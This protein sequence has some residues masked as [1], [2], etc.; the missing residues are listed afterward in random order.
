MKLKV[1]C[2]QDIDLNTFGI[3]KNLQ[4]KHN[5]DLFSII[6]VVNG[7][8]KFFQK[9]SL[10]KYLKKWFYYDHIFLNK[11]PD[12]EY[13]RS[14]E[15]NYKIDIWKIAYNDRIFFQYTD[16]Y[17]FHPDEILSIIEQGCK[18]FESILDEINPDFVVLPTTNSGR[19]HLFYEMCKAKNIPV[20]MLVAT[21]FGNRCMFSKEAEVIDY[22]DKL[23]TTN[24][25]RTLEELQN[26]LQGHDSYKSNKLFQNNQQTSKLQFFKAAITYFLFSK[27]SNL[28]TRY[29]HFGRTKSRVFFYYIKDMIKKNYRANFMN[30]NLSTKIDDGPFIFFPMITDPERSLLIAAPFHTNQF[31]LIVHIVKS[32]PIGYKLY[33]KDHPQMVTRDWRPTSFYKKIMELPNVKLLHPSTNP[34]D[35]LKKC[36]LVITIGGTTGLEAAF[37]GKPTITFVNTIYS[38]LK[39]VHVLKNIED[40]PNIIRSQLTKK[41]DLDDLN[42]F[43]N[44][45]DKNSV[46]FNHHAIFTDATQTFFY[47][48]FLADIEFKSSVMDEFL[49]RHQLEF[50]RLGLDLA[51]KFEQHQK[52]KNCD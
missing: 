50:D 16:F 22:Y 38:K 30:K 48:G 26:Y 37:Y 20:L 9:Q 8:Q 6:D 44:L 35:I 49:Q 13:L 21:R 10:V 40:L 52:Y 29:T 11:K 39:S 27:N 3:A 28:K 45:I 43:V 7:P 41:V 5:C 17:E 31:E 34:N 18:L 4:D 23:S 32:L 51:R 2:Y 36:S 14:I 1:L 15:K 24:T 33:V 46:E 19:M 12:F 25:S 42:S 47:N